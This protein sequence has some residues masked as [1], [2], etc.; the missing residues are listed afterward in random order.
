MEKKVIIKGKEFVA[1]FNAN[2]ELSK[3][4][5][6]L[7]DKVLTSWPR[8]RTCSNGV[9]IIK[10]DGGIEIRLGWHFF[11]EEE[12]EV[13]R[14]YKKGLNTG[15]GTPKRSSVPPEFAK[16][17]LDKCRKQLSAEAIAFFESC[18]KDPKVEA[19]VK[20]M[21]AAGLTEEQARAVFASRG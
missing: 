2:R 6:G 13:Y 21:I 5:V 10:I 1:E 7:D 11:T 16:E 19:A 17:V 4:V 14:N 9:P 15:S 8:E 18:V 12:K 20:A 3:A